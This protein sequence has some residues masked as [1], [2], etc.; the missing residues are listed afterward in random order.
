MMNREMSQSTVYITVPSCIF[1]VTVVPQR[2]KKP[3][4]FDA[5]SISKT[6]HGDPFVATK[7][8]ITT[9]GSFVHHPEDLTWISDPERYDAP[10]LRTAL[11]RNVLGTDDD[12]VAG[13]P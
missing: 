13:Y 3:T 9:K 10:P 4:L 11:H 6:H 7:S 1:Q 12:A 2:L 5:L 8:I